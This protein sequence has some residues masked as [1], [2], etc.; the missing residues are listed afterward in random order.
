MLGK[1]LS[2]E[3]EVNS[4]YS[5]EA[6]ND[7]M[8]L[9][10][11]LVLLFTV[12]GFTL[13]FIDKTFWALVLF[14]VFFLLLDLILRLLRNTWSSTKA[15][16]VA[17]ISAVLVF[18]ALWG[19]INGFYNAFGLLMVSCGFIVG[20]YISIVKMN[21]ALAWIPFALFFAYFVSCWLV[22]VDT[23][24]I[25][26]RNSRNYI[27]VVLLGLFST[28]IVL[29]K[30]NRLSVF[31]CLAALGVFCVSVWAEGRSGIIAS[32]FLVLILIASR[33]L[34]L[35]ITFSRQLVILVV[36]FM[37]FGF[38]LLYYIGLF[39]RLAERGFT[40]YSRG[41]IISEYFSGI[42]VSEIF[43][44]RNY[45]LIDDIGHYG[46][47]LHNSFLASWASGGIFYFIF[48][49]LIIFSV[50]CRFFSIPVFALA[51]LPLSIRAA[52]DT[53]IFFGKYDYIVFSLAFLLLE[54]RRTVCD[55]PRKG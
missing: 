15:H 19:L 28:A 18:E 41:R 3:M 40:D 44:G 8:P 55:A 2:V 29:S 21:A 24:S 51:L 20:Y 25:L 12:F 36:L 37:V 53:Q 45:F 54:K 30:P 11:Q 48:L 38:S 5:A 4:F 32:F 31:I 47:N 7:G 27:S 42:S 14:G 33:V 9:S 26:P 6:T 17:L 49:M 46:F 52:T 16:F 50:S 23:N 39:D 13:S 43:F 34:G 35:K 10:H 22:G 1:Q